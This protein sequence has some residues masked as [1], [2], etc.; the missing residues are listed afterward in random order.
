LVVSWSIPCPFIE[1]PERGS[2]PRLLNC[3]SVLSVLSCSTCARAVFCHF[4]CPDPL[5]LAVLS[6]LVD[7]CYT[8]PPSISSGSRIR[9]KARCLERR[10][11]AH[12]LLAVASCMTR[13]E[14]YNSSSGLPPNSRAASHRVGVWSCQ[15]RQW[16]A[17]VLLLLLSKAM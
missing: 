5:Q 11:Y 17:K 2:Q 6:A 9:D 14:I 1:L 4:P 13:L 3:P 16:I 10:A 15:Q 12:A 8:T 7:L